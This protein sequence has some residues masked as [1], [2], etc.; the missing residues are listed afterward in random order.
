MRLAGTTLRLQGATAAVVGAGAI[1]D[2][3]VLRRPGA[4]NL[5]GPPA[6]LQQLARRTGVGVC[7]VVVGE[8]VAGE[9]PVL[10][11]GLIED[12]DVGLDALLVHQPLKHLGRAVGGVGGQTL[13]PQ[14]QAF[15]GALD[16]GSAGCQ[17]ALAHGG[18]R[19]D[20][21]DHRVIQVDQVVGAVGEAGRSRL[22]GRPAGG[23]IGE[24]QV[25]G[26]HLRGRAERL[27]VQHCQV[28]P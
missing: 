18:G 23:R 16:H 12:R 21:D 14:A 24:R 2:R 1:A 20:V 5:E 26:R 13:G 4:R 10:A 22:R 9:G 11:L 17:L 28:L 27:L 3:V 19:F 15:L 7:L 25:L 6:V 8:V